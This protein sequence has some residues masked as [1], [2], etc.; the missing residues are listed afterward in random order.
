MAIGTPTGI[1]STGEGPP[2][3]AAVTFS[4]TGAILS[5][6]LLILAVGNQNVT[7][8]IVSN[9]STPGNSFTRAVRVASATT[10]MDC[11]IWYKSGAAPEAS[12]V[13][14]T[15][16]L[17]ATPSQAV[18]AALYKVTGVKQVSALDKTASS[19]VSTTSPSISSGTLSSANQILFGALAGTNAETYTEASGFSNLLNNLTNPVRFGVGYK[20]VAATTSVTYGPTVSVGNHEAYVLASFVASP[21]SYP[22]HRPSLRFYTGRF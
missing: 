4:T 3:D 8:A 18:I 12:G 19:G 5:S 15:I 6:D 2:A 21:P 11:E 1:G 22:P 16:N 7:T 9:A 20:I 14:V 13:T 17:D 10:Y